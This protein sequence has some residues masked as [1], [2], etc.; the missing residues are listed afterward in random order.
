MLSSVGITLF[1]VKVQAGDANLEEQFSWMISEAKRLRQMSWCVIVVVVSDDTV[2]LA[3]FAEWSLKGR[4]LMWSTRLLVVAHLP[5]QQLQQLHGTFSMT[6]SMLLIIKNT[7]NDVMCSIFIHLPF[8]LREATALEIAFWTAHHGLTL[9]S[10]LPLFPDKFSTFSKKPGLAV[11]VDQTHVRE[12]QNRKKDDMMDYFAQSINFTYKYVHPRDGS[13][14]G[15]VEMV[16]DKE[17]DF[18]LGPFS[19]SAARAEMVDFMWPI[20]IQY[21]RILAGRGLP[22]V[23]PWGFLLPLDTLV[24]VTVLMTLLI[25]LFFMFLVLWCLSHNNVNTHDNWKT[26]AFNLLR[27]LLQQDCLVSGSWWWKRLLFL[28]WMMMIAQVL[29]KS[30]SGNLMSSLA[31]RYI[32]Q[33]YQTLRDLLDDTSAT[34]MWQDSMFEPFSNN[35]GRPRQEFEESNRAMDDT[36]AELAK[37]AHASKAKL[38]IVGDF[39]H[40]EIERENLQPLG[41]PETSRAKMMKVSSIYREVHEVGSKRLIMYRTLFQ[42]FNSADT[43]VRHGRYVII[44]IEILISMFVSN[45]F[46]HTG[47]CDFYKSRERLMPA[48][49][50]SIAQKGSPLIPAFNKRILALTEAGLYYQWLKASLPNSTSCAH[51][52]TKITVSSSLSLNNI[53][54]MFVILG[55]GLILSTVI[56]CLE[57]VSNFSIMTSKSSMTM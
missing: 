48:I 53:W 15:L 46:S 39:N 34:M 35:S 25:L 52:P 21:S 57:I 50:A 42:F 11:A 16:R 49:L 8:S 14:Y 38:L 19:L 4:L 55:G 28:L 41:G 31:V 36:L 43:L 13:W 23:D 44:Q 30:Y 18:A 56:F 32:S 37:G 6:N 3:A 5:L 7:G 12:V 47:R 27:V 1:E 24:W 20:T 54:G 17:A 10:N 26:D 45:D 9:A 22:E 33:P 51:P 29:I 2:F 40:K